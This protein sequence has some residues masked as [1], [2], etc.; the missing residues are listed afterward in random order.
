MAWTTHHLAVLAGY[1]TAPHGLSIVFAVM[2][3]SL[4]W[5]LSLAWLEPVYKATDAQRAVLDAKW[6]TLNIPLYNEDPAIVREVLASLAAQTRR[7]DYVQVV[8]DCSDAASYEEVKVWWRGVATEAGIRGSWVRKAA[9]GGKRSAQ[10]VTFANDTQAD[11]FATMDS[12]VVLSPT[13][14]EEAMLPFADERVSSVAA[15]CVARN[16][17]ENIVSRLSDLWFLVFQLSVRS[18]L[19]SLR[20][21]LVNSGSFAVYR[22]DVVREA[23]PAYEN[24]TFM[25]RGVQFSDDSLLTLFA[26]LKGRTVQQPTSLAFTVLPARVSHHLRQQL[27]WLRGST[28]RSIWRFKYLPIVS[29]GYWEHFMSWVSYFVVGT[30]LVYLLAYQPAVN[31]ELAPMLLVFSSLVGYLTALKYLTIRRSDV[32]FRW[33]LATFAMTPLALAWST[34]VLRPLRIYAI[35][36]CWKTGWGTRQTVEVTQAIEAAPEP[37]AL[38]VGK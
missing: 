12:D 11:Y 17:R 34:L 24:E 19:S 25:G 38:P 8:D 20:S 9:N 27:R 2:F 21:V 1:G 37:L 29:F 13:A 6:V 31:H 4:I 28:I 7:P 36:T 22:A 15:V 23:I 33:Q 14:L 5:H 18:A 35:A 26:Y 32:S 30:V 3:G 16:A 10:L